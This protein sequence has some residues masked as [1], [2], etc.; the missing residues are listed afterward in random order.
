MTEA[1]WLT[2]EDPWRMLKILHDKGNGRKLR[3]LLCAF[4]RQSWLLFERETGC[5]G[6]ELAEQSADGLAAKKELRSARQAALIDLVDGMGWREE[7][8][9]FMLDRFDGFHFEDEPTWIHRMAVRFV[10]VRALGESVSMRHVTQ[11][12][13][14]IAET[15]EGASD[16]EDCGL[17]RE[18]F[19]NPFRPIT[20]NPTWRTTDVMSSAQGIYDKSLRSDADFGGCPPRRWMRQHRHPRPLPRHLAHARPRLLGA[21]LG[22]GE[23]V[24][25]GSRGVSTGPGVL[26]K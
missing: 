4:A 12:L 24:A 8:A 10:T 11:V 14:A 22:V 13:F 19:G 20:F 26:V 7:D 9:D 23:S 5:R 25:E 18:L 1:E 21:R 15:C 17:I 2:C 6:I 16:S 3:L